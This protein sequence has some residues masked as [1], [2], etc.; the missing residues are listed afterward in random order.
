MNS[1]PHNCEPICD[2]CAEAAAADIR[3]LPLDYFDLKRDCARPAGFSDVKIARPN[4]TGFPP[5]DLFVDE[6]CADIAWTLQVWEPP[7]REVIRA[8]PEPTTRVRPGWAVCVAAR[9]LA[10]HVRVLANLPATVGYADG[11]AAGPVTRDGRHGLDCL[12]TLHRRSRARLG[13]NRRV[14][15]LP[16]DCSGCGRWTLRRADG[17]DTV[18]CDA[19]KRAWTYGDYQRY[20]NLTT[21]S[22]GAGVTWPW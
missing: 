20:V 14:F 13:V 3:L 2:D 5:I 4:A 16:G 21:A 9:L 1:Q 12:R 8:A 22:M 7:V 15:R 18:W 11:L 10:N 6:L 17:G 19:C